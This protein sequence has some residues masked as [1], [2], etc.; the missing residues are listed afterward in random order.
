[1]KK[2]FYEV[3]AAEVILFAEQDIVTLSTDGSSEAPE[4]PGVDPN[5]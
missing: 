5:L 4:L 3:P 1:M 2:E